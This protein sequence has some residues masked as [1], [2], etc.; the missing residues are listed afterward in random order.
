MRF[1]PGRWETITPSAYAYLPFGAGPRMCMGAPLA[2][3]IMKIALATILQRYHFTMVPGSRING[4]VISTMLTPT[5]SVP[6]SITTPATPFTH[7]PVQGNIHDLVS[8]R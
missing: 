7:T 4:H 5:T 6:M 2:I 8:L 1:R 3:M